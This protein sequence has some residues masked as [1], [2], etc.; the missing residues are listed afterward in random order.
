MLI[1]HDTPAS[2]KSPPVVSR[3]NQTPTRWDAPAAG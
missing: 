2:S 1:G 3:Q